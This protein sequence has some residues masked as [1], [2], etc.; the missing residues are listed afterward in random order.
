[1]KMT[2]ENA[3][4]FYNEFLELY[5]KK[6]T[7][8]INPAEYSIFKNDLIEISISFELTMVGENPD[9]LDDIQIYVR[10]WIRD[11]DKEEP[12]LQALLE[13]Y[14]VANAPSSPEKIFEDPF[15]LK[16]KRQEIWNCFVH[17]LSKQ[18]A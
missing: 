5:S 7:H 11:I 18:E 8:K 2:Y 1:M 9:R 6:N 12:G 16:K 4:K 13:T 10:Y 17:V 15:K 14:S 3:E